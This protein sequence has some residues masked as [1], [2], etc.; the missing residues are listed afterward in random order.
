MML[1]NTSVPTFK[2][3]PCRSTV[4]TAQIK[5]RGIQTFCLLLLVL[6][7]RRRRCHSLRRRRRRRRLRRRRRRQL[8]MHIVLG[9]TCHGQSAY[10][11]SSDMP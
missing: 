4:N 7:L 1:E 10:S 11:S 9:P 3:A 6:V 2:L 8:H 5:K